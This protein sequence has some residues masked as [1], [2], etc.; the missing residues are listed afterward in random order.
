MGAQGRAKIQELKFFLRRLLLAIP[1]L[2]G[3]LTLLFL[4][5][6]AMPGDASNYYFH[7]DLPPDLAEKMRHSLGLADPLWMQ[8]FRWLGNALTLDFQTSLI[9]HRP[10]LAM[11]AQALPRTLLLTGVSLVLIYVLGVALGV[12]AAMRQNRA[13]GKALDFLA[14]LGLS[15]PTFFASLLLS[16]VFAYALGWFPISGTSSVNADLLSPAR[17]FVDGLWHLCLP[18]LA[19]TLTNAPI[20]ARYA[21]AGVAEALGQDFVRT[22][23]GKGLAR[24]RLVY[25]HILRGALLPLITLLGLHLPFLVSGAVIVETIFSW[26]GMGRLLMES[27]I[28][29]D[30]PVVLAAV[31]FLSAFVI[32]GSALADALYRA[33]DPRIR[34]S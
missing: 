12:A 15:M 7:P 1:L 29:R 33:A 27:I 21:R 5:L 3:V 20:V 8:Y 26:N 32:L 24:R 30:T 11:I 28:Q 22:A 31:F 34:E 14:L 13:S 4:L 25:G 16:F 17:Q 2:W 19:L 18:A 6:H 23:A 10:A 9:T